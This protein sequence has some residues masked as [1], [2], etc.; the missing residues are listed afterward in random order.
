MATV[1]RSE[2]IVHG[3]GDTVH[4]GGDAAYY[5]GDT[6]RGGGDAVYNRGDAVHSGGD[7]SFFP[8]KVFSICRPDHLVLTTA[9]SEAIIDFY[10]ALGMEI[11]TF[12]V[13]FH[14]YSSDENIFTHL[15]KWEDRFSSLV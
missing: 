5:R 7:T 4:G 15:N 6:V 1:G 12:G 2:H 3:G 9:N 11:K 10:T 13:S 8:S 14:V